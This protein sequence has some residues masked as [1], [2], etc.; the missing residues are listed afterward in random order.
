MNN[1]K[2]SSYIYFLKDKQQRDLIIDSFDYQPSFGEISNSLSEKWKAMIPEDKIKYQTLSDNSKPIN[3]IK[4]KVKTPYT[5]YAMDKNVKDSIKSELLKSENKTF[6]Q[7]LAEKWRNLD[8]EVKHEYESLSVK[9]NEKRNITRKKPRT[10]YVF[11][12]SDKK[13]RESIKE[14]ENTNDFSVISK[15]LS[16]KWKNMDEIDKTPYLKLSNEDSYITAECFTTRKRARTAYT[17]Y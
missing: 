12:I 5:I 3:D 14:S 15:K 16:E 11:F 7:L 6:S 13:V 4:L 8:S 10:A 17:F 2:I 9:Y 1:R